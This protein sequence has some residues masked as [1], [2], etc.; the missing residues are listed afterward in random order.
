MS[1]PVASSLNLLKGIK[2]VSK[3]MRIV[4]LLNPLFD[5]ERE[6]RPDA[7]VDSSK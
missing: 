7:E 4:P 2:T 1:I 5:F 6:Q 3:I